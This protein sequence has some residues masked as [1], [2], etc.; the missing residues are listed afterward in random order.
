M[1]A[2]PS[3]FEERAGLFVGPAD[4][5]SS[6]T[7]SRQGAALLQERKGGV[8]RLQESRNTSGLPGDNFNVL[9]A[10][11]AE[12]LSIPANLIEP[13]TGSQ[14]YLA[15]NQSNAAPTF[16]FYLCK[17]YTSGST[18]ARGSHC[19]F[20]HSRHVLA[21]VSHCSGRVK[22][23]QVHWSTPIDSMAEAVYERHEPGFVFHINQSNFFG[24]TSQTSS[25]PPDRRRLASEHVYKTKGSESAMLH[26]SGMMLRLCKH[27]EREKCARGRMCRFVHRVHLSTP[28]PATLSP[29]MPAIVP[30]ISA[31][32]SCN[33]TV[34]RRTMSV[35]QSPTN[36]QLRLSPNVNCL[37]TVPQVH[38]RHNIDLSFDASGVSRASGEVFMA[39]SIMLPAHSPS[40]SPLQPTL[41]PQQLQNPLPQLHSSILRHPT[42]YSFTPVYTPQ[43]SPYMSTPTGQMSATALQISASYYDES[44]R[45]GRLQQNM[46][47]KL[48]QQ[49]SVLPPSPAPDYVLSQVLFTLM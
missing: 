30:T 35:C 9:S 8:W 36:T 48:Q 42:G 13:T 16:S 23:I 37:K 29:S 2:P 7:P 32:F 18:C 45:Y 28:A 20:I 5:S 15:K 21:D 11:K 1:E 14:N 47:S 24:N 19:D 38:P 27:Y 22:S 6:F 33:Q 44:Q 10:D 39:P 17:M 26:G 4:S 3:L 43:Q 34:D 40:P 25:N 31:P 12:T 49:S 41:H 46:T